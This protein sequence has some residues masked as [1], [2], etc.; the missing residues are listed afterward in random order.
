VWFGDVETLNAEVGGEK[1]GFALP[2]TGGTLW[3]DNFLIPIGSEEKANAEALINYY[4]EPQVAATVAAYVNYI[5]PVEGA[6]AAMARIN[7]AFVDD[8]LIFPNE[9]TL[10]QA[11]LFHTL[12]MPEQNTYNSDFEGV[13][14]GA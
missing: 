10:R 5:T 3:S 14:L 11:H 12:T 8:Q 7:P 9:D 2:E 6:Q 13:L 1:F 4:Y